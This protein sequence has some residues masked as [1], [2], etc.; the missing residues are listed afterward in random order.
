M[1]EV[2]ENVTQL[3][4]IQTLFVITDVYKVSIYLFSLHLFYCSLNCK[5]IGILDALRV[6]SVF[7]TI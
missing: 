5:Y 6:I 2:M 3:L 4:S 7:I 1:I